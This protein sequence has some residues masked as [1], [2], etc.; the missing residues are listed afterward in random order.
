M[1]TTH[2]TTSI[3]TILA[4]AVFILVSIFSLATSRAYAATGEQIQITS[5]SFTGKSSQAYS[6]ND[7]KLNWT[8]STPHAGDYLTVTLP[9]TLVWGSTLTYPMTN[10][11]GATIGSC[12]STTHTLT[13]TLDSNAEKYDSLTGS[14]Q[15][16]ASIQA[17]AVGH[18]SEEII[19]SS[20]TYTVNYPT[21]VTPQ[22]DTVNPGTYKFGWA[23]H[24][25]QEGLIHYGW[26]IY[27]SENTQRT[28]TD[29][30]ATPDFIQCAPQGTTYWDEPTIYQPETTKTNHTISWN[31]KNPTDSCRAK[32]WSTSNQAQ[33]KNVATVN[34]TTV[35]YTAHYTQSGSANADGT[36]TPTTPTTPEKPVKPQPAQP[37]T[38]TTPQ[39]K[40]PHKTIGTTTKPQTTSPH[41][42]AHTGT[43]TTPII[44]MVLLLTLTG[45]ALTLT[46]HK[47]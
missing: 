12:T 34:S 1:K 24:K 6:F 14:V 31:V 35:D 38:P 7:L 46:T 47:H 44:L 21:K 8:T 32:F 30:T 42:L 29:P 33:V 23:S 36:T 18:T 37:N 27:T 10:T 19:T 20:G 4:L 40:Q 41:Q 3:K 9:E 22:R 45:L 25:D 17:S 26:W 28:I 11:Q 43:T 13:C 16:T 2:H 39:T 15:Q 5:L